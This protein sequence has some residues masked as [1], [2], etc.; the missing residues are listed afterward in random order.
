MV[1]NGALCAVFLGHS[2]ICLFSCFS[3][4]FVRVLT[5][6]NMNLCVCT[7]IFSSWVC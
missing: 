1:L 2:S 7:D 6:G 3:Y 5:C 4:P